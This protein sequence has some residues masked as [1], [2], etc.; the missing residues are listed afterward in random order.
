MAW[1]HASQKKIVVSERVVFT[2]FII[3]WIFCQFSIKRVF[4]VVLVHLGLY[5]HIRQGHMIIN[6]HK[7]MFS[8]RPRCHWTMDGYGSTS[9]GIYESF[10]FSQ[11]AENQTTFCWLLKM[12]FQYGIV[13]A[14]NW[15][16]FGLTVLWG[17]QN[18]ISQLTTSMNIITNKQNNKGSQFQNL[19]FFISADKRIDIY[20]YGPSMLIPNNANCFT[21][22]PFISISFGLA[23]CDITK[24]C[25]INNP[26]L[27]PPKY[28]G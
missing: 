28:S 16:F 25:L 21:P 11:K 10:K 13:P 1:E 6:N 27:N 7:S 2:I 14:V 4:L 9:N 23:R 5:S 3:L 26:N 20:E 24:N 15:S 22:K 12:I 8:H 19:S 18:L 17:R